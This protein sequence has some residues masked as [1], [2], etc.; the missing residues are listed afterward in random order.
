MLTHVVACVL[1]YI[2]SLFKQSAMKLSFEL[3][4]VLSLS[5]NVEAMSADDFFTGQGTPAAVHRLL[6]GTSETA[7][8]ITII[9]PTT[10]L[11]RLSVSWHS[12][13]IIA[14]RKTCSLPVITLNVW[15]ITTDLKGLNK[16]C[17][18]FGI[19]GEPLKV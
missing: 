19:T 14:L 3:S 4:Q 2:G 10:V 13:I 9:I 1:M 6:A 17:G 8:I 18:Q 16:S 11:K 15:I 12:S 7:S 5:P